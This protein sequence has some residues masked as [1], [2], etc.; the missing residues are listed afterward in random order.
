MSS[1]NEV[2]DRVYQRRYDPLDISVCIVAGSDGLLL[3]DQHAHSQFDTHGEYSVFVRYI[4]R[5]LCRRHWPTRA[6]FSDKCPSSHF[7]RP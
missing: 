2:A 3:V 7:E 5:N 1:W 4:S 6:I